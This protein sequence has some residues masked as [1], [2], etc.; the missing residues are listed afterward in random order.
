MGAGIIAGVNSLRTTTEYAVIFQ[1]LTGAE[2]LEYAFTHLTPE[3]FTVSELADAFG[4]FSRT[5]SQSGTSGVVK[6]SSSL[7]ESK[8]LVGG[9][10]PNLLK[11]AKAA[12]STPGFDLVS[13]GDLVDS[14]SELALR[15]RMAK[16]ARTIADQLDSLTSGVNSDTGAAQL[17][18]VSQEALTVQTHVTTV[19]DEVPNL[20]DRLSGKVPDTPAL[21]TSIPE[22]NDLLNGGVRPGE[23]FV[24]AAR[25]GC[26]KTTL[27]LNFATHVAFEA[28]K[29]VYFK[30]LEMSATEIM[31][32]TVAST[33]HV[34]LS[35]LTGAHSSSD[36]EMSAIQEGIGLL[37][38]CGDRL[39][40]D[41]STDNTLA[42]FVAQ[43]RLMKTNLGD[44]LGMVVV[45]Y[46]QLMTSGSKENRV[47]DISVITRSLKL[48]AKDLNVPIIALSQLNRESEKDR[49]SGGKP[50]LDN[51][52]SSGSI[53]QDANQV[54]L[55]WRYPVENTEDYSPDV[56]EQPDYYAFKG[57]LEKNRNGKT[58]EFKLIPQLDQ[59]LFLSAK[60]EKPW[61]G[62][63]EPS[64]E[65]L[66]NAPA[67]NFDSPF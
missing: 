18:A 9:D 64:R 66:N 26:G 37:K 21:P 33:V 15:S 59:S 48:L 62:F 49:H 39:V 32:K 41:D 2:G 38:E 67:I 44:D 19:R 24:V 28:G 16:K 14:L 52:R 10:Y 63:E 43:A 50:R 4:A 55:L 51:L 60:E 42:G 5:F 23:L 12:M 56:S 35:Y 25:P 53:E 58:G 17:Y 40:V 7:V 36:P 8:N 22:L 30:S 57:L 11:R 3:D 61:G 1:L 31:N 20:L 54:L 34:P 45:D 29:A 46:L 6:V 65:H 27:A 47:E 13:V